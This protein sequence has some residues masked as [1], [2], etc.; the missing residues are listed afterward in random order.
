MRS[1]KRLMAVALAMTLVTGGSRVAAGEVPDEV[2]Q[3][4]QKVRKALAKLPYYGVFDFLAFSLDGGVVTLK[5]FAHRPALKREAEAMIRDAVKVDVANKIEILPTSSFDD[6][7]RW[8]TFQRVYTDDIAS[9]YVP[10]GA[11]EVRYEIL[12][13]ARFPGMEPYGTY[14]VHIVV[15]NRRVLLIGLLDND[16]DKTLVVFRARQVPNIL[17]IEDAVSVRRP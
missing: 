4:T 10:G 17:A 5:G 2:Q 14:P 15:K 16:L 13:M 9:K 11:M 7:I 8:S 12:D 6:R 3:T 1:A